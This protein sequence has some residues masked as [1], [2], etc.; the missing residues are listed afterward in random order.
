MKSSA[1]ASATVMASKL[2]RW[3]PW[4]MLPRCI[5]HQGNCLRCYSI[6]FTLIGCVANSTTTTTTATKKKKSAR[7][8]CMHIGG[9]LVGAPTAQAHSVTRARWS[10]SIWLSV[11]MEICCQQPA[12]RTEEISSEY[13]TLQICVS[14]WLGFWAKNNS[15]LGNTKNFRRGLINGHMKVSELES[16]CWMLVH[17]GNKI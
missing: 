9:H 2:N 3:T 15:H 11:P 12:G 16:V 5:W 4:W 8:I 10:R 6:S 14:L 17:Y 7:S 1:L 13:Q